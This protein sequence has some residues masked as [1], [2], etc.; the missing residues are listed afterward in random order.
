MIWLKD[1]LILTLDVNV[2]ELGS[3]KLR[4]NGKENKI[5]Q[6]PVIG[7]LILI[8]SYVV[9]SNANIGSLGNK[10]IP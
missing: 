1:S 7:K 4:N 6:A 2:L 3:L 5:I 9:L 10:K 8:F